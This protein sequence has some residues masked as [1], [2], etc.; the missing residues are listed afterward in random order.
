MIRSAQ[1]LVRAI[2]TYEGPTLE[3]T[4]PGTP[5]P[6]HADGRSEPHSRASGHIVLPNPRGERGAMFTGGS[7]AMSGMPS[8]YG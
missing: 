2:E 3:L 5:N 1:D 7:L 4:V 8:N 6:P